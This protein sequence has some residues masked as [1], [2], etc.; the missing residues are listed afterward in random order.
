M[1]KS[2]YDQM[3]NE[4]NLE[5]EIYKKNIKIKNIKRIKA[6][7]GHTDFVFSLTVLLDGSLACGSNDNTIERMI[8]IQRIWNVSNGSTINWT[9]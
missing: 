8:L 1:L 7:F 5:I 9:Q 4:K 2:K 6:L 3:L